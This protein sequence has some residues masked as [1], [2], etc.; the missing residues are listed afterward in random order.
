MIH[1]QNGEGTAWRISPLVQHSSHREEMQMLKAG[2][3]AVTCAYVSWGLLL[4]CLPKGWKRK[5]GSVC[6]GRSCLC[7]SPSNSTSPIWTLTMHAVA[8]ITDCS[9]TFHKRASTVTKIVVGSR[10]RERELQHILS[11]H[12][13]SSEESHQTLIKLSKPGR[14]DQL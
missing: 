6:S 7:Q 5:W 1:L 9:S 3:S 8:S 10:E 13:G 4:A 2:R 11:F 14:T 12:L